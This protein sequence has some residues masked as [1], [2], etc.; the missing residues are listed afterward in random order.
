MQRLIA[1]RLSRLQITNARMAIVFVAATG[2]CLAMAPILPSAPWLLPIGLL[3]ACTVTAIWTVPRQHQRLLAAITVA[4]VLCQL[5]VM[6]TR[7]G[8]DPAGPTFWYDDREYFAQSAAVADAW[9]ANIFPD[10]TRKGSQP[11]FLGTLHTGY[12]RSLASAFY[13]FGTKP[14]AGLFLNLLSAAVLPLFCYLLALDLRLRVNSSAAAIAAGLAALHPTQLYWSQFLLKDLYLAAWFVASLWLLVRMFQRRDVAAGLAFLAA[15][16]VLYT[17]RVYCAASLLVAAIAYL[18]AQL[19]RRV[20]WTVFAATALI[21]T[22]TALYTDR[23]AA[24]FNQMWSSLVELGP[25]SVRSPWDVPGHLLAGIPRLMLGPFAWLAGRGDRPLY[26]LYPGMWF[27]YLLV[28]PAAIVAFV[29]SLRQN[30]KVA[31]LPIMAGIGG[32]LI[33]LTASYGGDAPRQR[34]YMEYICIAF[35]AY[36]WT[37]PKRQIFIGYYAV[38]AT[39]IIGQVITVKIRGL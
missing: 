18:A 26:G 36:G 9:K 7:L 4:V 32:A 31:A 15:T 39:Y 3:I 16:Y 19:P 23:G 37:L 6:L 38:L 17:I 25:K 12:H 22:M 29:Y 2:I 28:Y 30:V 24:R 5:V 13:V 8:Y 14:L 35:A 10:I 20:A 1:E 34:Y 27:M 21:I 11:Y 33:L